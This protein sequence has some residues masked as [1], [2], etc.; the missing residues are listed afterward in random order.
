MACGRGRG[1]I[2]EVLDG[3]VRQMRILQVISSLRRSAGTSVFAKKL[4]E[5]LSA[6]GDDVTIALRIWNPDSEYPTDKSIRIVLLD[7]LMK[8]GECSFDIVHIHA[9]WQSNTHKATKWANRA[10]VPIVWSPH[11][12]L[13]P[14]ALRYKWWKKVLALIAYQWRDLNKASM[15]HVTAEEEKCDLERLRLFRPFVCAPLGVDLRFTVQELE[16]QAIR[17]SDRECKTILFLSRIHPVKGLENLVRAWRKL[18]ITI[19]SDWQVII[20]GPDQIG[21]VDELKALCQQLGVQ[22]DFSFRGP[23][24]G[25]QKDRLFLDSDLFVLP[26]FSEN[27]GSVIVESLAN[28]TPAI[29]TKGAPWR[30]LEER[31]CGWWIDIGV[32][33]LKEAL[34]K[35]MSL[36][37]A[38]RHAMGM[39]GRRL[40]EEKYTW[41]SVAQKMR[42]SYLSLVEEKK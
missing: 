10:G 40:V 3:M 22:G 12:S 19:R 31:G 16:N 27:F 4:S 8:E 20:A 13:K 11:G 2:D 9:L 29:C 33:P 36:S 1:T 34:E 21:Y 5:K 17:T 18:D 41:H 6:D 23:T 39:K 28:G 25:E 30:E 35:A 14:W 32:E 26:T 7:D 42:S 37:D 24:Y 38:E 15:Y